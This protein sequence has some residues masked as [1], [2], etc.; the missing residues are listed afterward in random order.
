VGEDDSLENVYADGPQPGTAYRDASY[1][2][3]DNED[4]VERS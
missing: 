2:S 3:N 1:S 4:S